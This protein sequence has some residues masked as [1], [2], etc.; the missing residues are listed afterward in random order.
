MQIINISWKKK[1]TL[2]T[3]SMKKVL[4]KAYKKNIIYKNHWKKITLY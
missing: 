1:E 2:L 3:P 4:L